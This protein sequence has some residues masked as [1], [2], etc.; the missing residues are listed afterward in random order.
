MA[1][2][3]NKRILN[4]MKKEGVE[5]KR[6][7]A[8]WSTAIAALKINKNKIEFLTIGDCVILGVFEDGKFELLNGF[9]EHDLETMIE[10]S[11]IRDKK[12]EEKWKILKAQIEKVRLKTN[13]DYGSMN[14]EKE[15]LKFIKS[16]KISK[17]GIESIILFTDGL[18]IPKKEPKEKEKWQ[19]TVDIYQKNGLDG[20]L[21][22]VRS[23]EK[24][25]P[26]CSKYPRFKQYDDVAAIGIDF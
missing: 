12:L 23:L 14:G 16:G 3:A 18:I 21:E 8:L 24:E 17:E 26:E 11:K 20:L 9:E 5:T 4:E 13:V 6:K 15:A 25:D 1:E 7:E 2:E 10:W 19:M 22:H